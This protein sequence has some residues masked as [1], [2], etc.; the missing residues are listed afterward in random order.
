MSYWQMQLNKENDDEFY[1][2]KQLLIETRV[3]GMDYNETNAKEVN[4]FEILMHKGDIVLI[5]NYN[6]AIALVQITG[7][8]NDLGR[9]KNKPNLDWFRFRRQVKVLVFLNNKVLPFSVNKKVIE[10]IQEDN[11]SSFEYIHKFYLKNKE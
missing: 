9:N 10:C 2:I 8:F 4:E 11:N 3:I 5:R 6:K 1:D 7:L